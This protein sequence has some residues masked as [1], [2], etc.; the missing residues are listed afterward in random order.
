MWSNVVI[1]S[2]IGSSKTSLKLILI[3]FNIH[4]LWIY[5]IYFNILNPSAVFLL[6]K[7]I[8][9]KGRKIGITSYVEVIFLRMT[10]YKWKAWDVYVSADFMCGYECHWMSESHLYVAMKYM[11]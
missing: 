9:N 7:V 8:C 10:H 5:L 4:I 1:K 6:L 3:L 11:V 2:L